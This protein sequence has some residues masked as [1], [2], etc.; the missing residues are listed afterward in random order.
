MIIQTQLQE[1]GLRREKVPV[2]V[3]R[4]EYLDIE[5]ERGEDA[6]TESF[7]QVHQTL[8]FPL[9]Y[10]G[11]VT[12]LHFVQAPDQT[13]FRTVPTVCLR[14]GDSNNERP[15]DGISETETSEDDRT[16]RSP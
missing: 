14:E 4:R 15:S 9:R 8:L 1:T 5:T 3:T 13:G 11:L 6:G 16:L 2:M 7:S 12:A 10:S